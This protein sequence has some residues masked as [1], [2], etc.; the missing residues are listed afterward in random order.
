VLQAGTAV[1]VDAYGVP[2]TKCL[3]GNPLTTP[4]KRHDRTSFQGTPWPGWNPDKVLTVK[5]SSTGVERFTLADTSEHGHFV[6]RPIGTRGEKD[7]P[8]GPES[9]PAST[10]TTT[11]AATTTTNPA[12]LPTTGRP[13]TTTPPTTGMPGPHFGGQQMGTS[14][15]DCS[16]RFSV[17]LAIP[18]QDFFG[19]FTGPFDVTGNMY[20]AN[21]DYVGN[22]EVSGT[23]TI[24]G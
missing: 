5:Q 7:T 6:D 21:G 16:G 20:N 17:T 2:R 10:T 9:L 18:N 15:T 11:T 23:F 19:T 13:P 3:C 14:P 12:G 1:L 24:T 4:A 22:S 8:I